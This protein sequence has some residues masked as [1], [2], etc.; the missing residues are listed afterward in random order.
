M[1]QLLLQRNVKRMQ[2]FDRALSLNP[3][4]MEA[5]FGKGLVGIN[6]RHFD[7]AMAAFDAALAIKPAM[8]PRSLPARP[9]LSAASGGSI[10]RPRR[11]STRR[12][13]AMPHAGDR[14][15]R[16]GPYRR[17]QRR[18]HRAGHGLPAR[19]CWSRTPSGSGSPGSA[20]AS[21]SRATSRSD[22]AVRPC[23]CG[24]A[25]L[26]RT[27]SPRRSLHSISARC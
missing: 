20:P 17:A 11:I 13:R 19:E 16:Q 14:V 10:S 21:P 4:H 1:A 23:A 8:P 3:R 5:M 18:Q 12:W 26:S 15:A 9:A 7:E 22:P 2:S 24:Q 27:R 6:L 25:G